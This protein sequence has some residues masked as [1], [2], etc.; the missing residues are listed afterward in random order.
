MWSSAAASKGAGDIAEE[1]KPGGRELLR[2]SFSRTGGGEL[3]DQVFPIV[4]LSGADEAKHPLVGVGKAAY[5]F[6]K[7]MRNQNLVARREAHPPLPYIDAS[8]RALR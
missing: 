8:P 6:V 3:I 4:Y 5:N 1:G 2:G 7:Q